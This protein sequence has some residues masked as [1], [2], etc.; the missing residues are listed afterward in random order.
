MS[1]DE[2]AAR[3]AI[4]ADHYHRSAESTSRRWQERNRQFLL[5]IGALGLAVLL[6]ANA[7]DTDTLLIGILAKFSGVTDDAGAKL[8]ESFPYVVVHGLLVVLVFYFMTDV[9]RLNANIIRNYEY[10]RDVERDIQRA[11]LLTDADTAFSKEGRFFDDFR[12]P[13]M[14]VVKIAYALIV[15]GMLGLFL[16]FRVTNDWPAAGFSLSQLSS[17][18][19]VALWVR[20]HFLLFVDVVVGGLTVLMYVGYLR[21]SFWPLKRVRAAAE[22]LQGAPG[23]SQPRS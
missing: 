21:I 4:L 16:T 7:N 8:R 1:D 23:S 19:E 18:A 20:K 5:L 12:V 6:T 11:M 22:V 15:G 2:S 10:L 17:G 9:F 3:I 14:W 13:W